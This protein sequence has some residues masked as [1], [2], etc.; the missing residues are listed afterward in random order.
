[1]AYDVLT[2]KQNDMVTMLIEGENVPDIEEIK[3]YKE[4]NICMDVKG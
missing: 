2:V 3:C 4:Y 1:M